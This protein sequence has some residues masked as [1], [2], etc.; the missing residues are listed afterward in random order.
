MSLCPATTI[1]PVFL[2]FGGGNRSEQRTPPNY[3]PIPHV[4]D[5]DMDRRLLFPAIA[6]T[7]WAQQPSQPAAEAL[8]DRVQQYY[9][10]MVDKK[11]RQAE[12]MVA[13]ESREDYYNGKKPDLKGFEIMNLDLLTP[14][15]AKVTIRVKVVVLMPGAG[16]QLFDMPTPT[17]W[18]LE[19]G[20][21]CWYIPEEVK[22]ATPFGQMKNTATGGGLDMKGAA[23]GGI[24]N[25]N[26]GSLVSQITIDKLSVRLSGQE[27]EQSVTI[28]NGLP[29]PVNLSLDSRVERI[30]GLKVEI[31][32]AQ[33][34][35]GGKAVVTIRRV[36]DGKLKDVV[37]VV[38]EPFHRIFDI[39]VETN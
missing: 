26:V 35:A 5:I 33:L 29:G 37:Q 15:T 22:A 30:T 1:S 8:R 32:P 25:P 7:A 24:D 13:M 28:T 17:Y 36:G 9:Q 19:N 38:A 6:A 20:A 3:Q 31:R 2:A 14:T 27:R 39:Q 18:I 11:Y 10:M 12:A 4:Y 23:P 16:G 34:Q 21:W